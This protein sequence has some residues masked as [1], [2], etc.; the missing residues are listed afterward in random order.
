[1]ARCGNF[2]IEE[3]SLRWQRHLRTKSMGSDKRQDVTM[4]SLVASHL[5]HVSSNRIPPENHDPRPRNR[6]EP[7]GVWR[8]QLYLM[9]FLQFQTMA[10]RRTTLGHPNDPGLTQITL[11]ISHHHPA[12]TSLITLLSSFL[13]PYSLFPPR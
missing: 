4:L 12:I 13:P 11:N 3:G 9:S 5:L 7:T 10:K 6:E 1:M 8:K 2:K